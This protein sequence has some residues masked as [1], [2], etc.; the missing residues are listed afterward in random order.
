M[1]CLGLGWESSHNF[2]SNWVGGPKYQTYKN[3]WGKG[4]IGQCCLQA[5]CYSTLDKLYLG[6]LYNCSLCFRQGISRGTS[7][8]SVQRSL[9][10]RVI[11]YVIHVYIHT[12]NP[13]NVHNVSEHLLS[14]VHSTHTSVLT[15]A[16]NSLSVT[17]V[18]KTFLP[19]EVSKYI[20]DCT[21]VSKLAS[22]DFIET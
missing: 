6:A 15:Q 19:M 1:F 17:C 9:R 12:R 5:V 8:L 7:V 20:L 21:L 14:R 22:L 4:W 3:I 18:I 2:Y 11:L 10:S 16:S 13:I